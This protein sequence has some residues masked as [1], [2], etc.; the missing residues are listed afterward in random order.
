MVTI[1]G[2]HPALI[3]NRSVSLLMAVQRL[4]TTALVHMKRVQETAANSCW[5]TMMQM[6]SGAVRLQVAQLT[7]PD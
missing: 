3:Q 6:K 4:A 1:E 7:F 2:K 5:R